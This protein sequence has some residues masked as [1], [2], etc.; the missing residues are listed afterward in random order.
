M[1]TCGSVG[2][3]PQVESLD[4]QYAQSAV[5]SPSDFAFPYDANLAETTPNTEQLI[6]SDL[7]LDELRYL[8]HEGSVMN[9]K[10][11]R[12]D[13]YEVVRKR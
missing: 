4:V 10:D 5:F 1:V 9:L 3:L 12:T 11:R 13:L 7:N 6:F 8:H 2:N